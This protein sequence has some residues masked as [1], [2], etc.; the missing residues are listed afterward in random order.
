MPVNSP[1]LLGNRLPQNILQPQ[2]VDNSSWVQVSSLNNFT[3]GIKSDST[4]HAWGVNNNF[5]VGI[6]LTTNR[7]LPVQISTSSFTLVS[8]GFDHS[9]A[10]TIDNTLFMWGNQPSIQTLTTLT[11]WTSISIGTSHLLA[12]RDNG[13]LWAWGWNSSGQLGDN[14]TINKSSPVQIG[15]SSYSMIFAGN[16]HSLAITVDGK[17][18]AWGINTFGQLGINETINRSSPVQ[19]T[20]SGVSSWIMISAGIN[21][22]MAVSETNI[23]YSWGQNNT[24][25]LGDETT[26][27]KSLPVQIGSG[28][29]SQISAANSSSSAINNLGEL[30]T[31]GA[32]TGFVLGNGT[33]INRSLPTQVATGTSWSQI[34]MG[35]NHSLALTDNFRLFSWGLNN[36]GQLGI[37]NTVNR[38]LPVQVGS[39][40]NYASISAK[41]DSSGA[42]DSAGQLFTWGLNDV[43]GQLGINITGNRSSPVQV[44]GSWSSLAVGFSTTVAL[45][46]SNLIYVWG[47]GNIGQLGNSLIGNRSNPTIIQGINFETKSPTLVPGNWNFVSAGQSFTAGISSNTL[48]TWGLNNTGQ[49]GLGN[50]ISRS[51]PTVVNVPTI[52]TNV[53]DLGVNEFTAL[54]NGTPSIQNQIVPFANTGSL[55][56]NGTTDFLTIAHNSALNFNIS[57]FLIDAWVYITNTTGNNQGIVSK[58]AVGT[59]GYSLFVTNGLVL[60]FVWDGI[61]GTTA[62]GGTLTLNTWNYVAIVRT[63]RT[64]RLYLNGT[65]G[66]SFSCNA[67]LTSTASQFIGQARGANPLAGYISNVRIVTDSLP[68]GYDAN[69]STVSVPSAPVISTAN[70]QL[71][72]LTQPFPYYQYAYAGTGSLYATTNDYKLYAW[73]LGTT[74]QISG[75]NQAISRSNPSL[76]GNQYI[77]VNVLSPA[78]IATGSWSFVTAGRSNS[79][80]V[81]NDG[82]LFTW[83]LNSIGQLG[84][85]S[86]ILKSSPVQISNSSWSQVSTYDSFVVGTTSDGTAY[87]WGLGTSGQLGDGSIISKSTPTLVGNNISFRDFSINSFTTTLAGPLTL[88]TDITPVPNSFSGSFNGSTTSVTLP[89]SAAWA[90]GTT[91]TI[92]FYLYLVAYTANSR[93]ITVNNDNISIDVYIE[94]GTN[95]LSLHGGLVGAPRTT[96]PFPRNVWTH[97]A[98]VYNS[99]NLSIYFNGVAQTITGQTTGFNITNS[100]NAYVGVF[101]G[102]SGFINGYISNLRVVKGTAVYT[103]NFTP[104]TSPLSAIAGTELLMFADVG[105][106]QF[107]SIST[108]NNNGYGVGYDY[109][110]YSWGVGTNGGL[111][112]NI[113]AARSRPTIVSTQSWNK[114]GAGQSNAGAITSEGYLFV[115]GFGLSGQLGETFA[116]ITRSG[117]NQV[118]A[119]Y[120]ITT[121]RTPTK[122]DGNLG[123]TSWS[124]I[125]AGESHTAGITNNKLF[126][127]GLNVAGQLG[128]NSTLNRSSP[129]QVTGTYSD[130][131]AGTSN[132]LAIAINYPTGQ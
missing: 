101:P 129:T 110:L 121:V 83:G 75:Y 57:D 73:G 16:T 74:G 9:G 118:G 72:L 79:A 96:I 55:L 117:I 53:I 88:R 111:G 36:L 105:K 78:Q 10:I 64:A 37:N 41:Q 14:T 97:V 116:S 34:S 58:G 123:T 35:V 68:V 39:L 21:H 19:L 90:L 115:W 108:G 61:D 92:E 28:S 31:W 54:V 11:S 13:T 128:I 24:G 107:S 132:T 86:T 6:G 30:Y 103:A 59:N 112:S 104:P 113:V 91:G 27:N 69:S 62:T 87:A 17:L 38:S 119:N 85:Q 106:Q 8:A 126:M 50:I 70:T 22:S 48:F 44:S 130:V 102:P 63:Q 127:W 124:S 45:D 56:L 26:I 7:S 66:A 47:L 131:S 95:F 4:L 3:A 1:V 94:T 46:S 100:S 77:S 29:W 18:F 5:Q 20:V 99:G 60:S 125:S 98:I 93:V 71:L 40:S 82:K 23:L 33:S 42:I 32:G 65:G 109:I 25:Q 114:V 122:I 67:D 52:P 81:K 2:L 12:I 76:I 120:P 89:A 80:A 43:V 15:S 49:L 51:S 84:D